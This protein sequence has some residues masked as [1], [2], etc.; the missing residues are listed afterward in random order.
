MLRDVVLDDLPAF[1]D[2]MQ[3]PE[4]IRMAA[5]TPEDPADREAFDAHWAR[6]L[7]DPAVVNRTVVFDGEVIGWLGAFDFEGRRE[8]TYWLARPYWGKGLATQALTEFLRVVPERPVYARAATDN[9][10]SLRVLEKTGFV[11]VGEDS[12]YAAGR[13]AETAEFLLELVR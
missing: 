8:V 4:A 13:G 3:D 6:I 5:F 1:F 2:C 11:V 9:V 7:D 10:G 12:G